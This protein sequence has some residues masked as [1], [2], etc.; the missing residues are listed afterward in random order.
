MNDRISRCMQVFV[1]DSGP[2]EMV[3][4]TWKR[5]K[6]NWT[7]FVK[8]INGNFVHVRNYSL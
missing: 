7:F 6:R 8:S 2:L 1:F 3:I 5:L 4:S